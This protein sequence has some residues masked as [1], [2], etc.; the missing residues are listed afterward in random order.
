MYRIIMRRYWDDGTFTEINCG[1]PMGKTYTEFNDAA[2][3][4][5]QMNRHLWRFHQ[6]K[7]PNTIHYVKEI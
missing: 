3:L 1:C 5:N 7:A 2:R 6:D 4:A